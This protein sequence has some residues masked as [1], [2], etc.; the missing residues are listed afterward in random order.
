MLLEPE[1]IALAYEPELLAPELLVPALALRAQPHAATELILLQRAEEPHVQR[2]APVALAQVELAP[3]R[4]RVREPA[5]VVAL[6][7]ALV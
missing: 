5:L 3:A 7:V 1:L 4:E 6:V 2:T